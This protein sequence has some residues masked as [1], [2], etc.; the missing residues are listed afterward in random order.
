[1]LKPL[2]G[3]RGLTRILNGRAGSAAGA[4]VAYGYPD[5]KRDATAYIMRLYINVNAGKKALYIPGGNSGRRNADVRIASQFRRYYEF[6]SWQNQRY[7]RKGSASSP[8][9]AR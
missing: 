7:A 9:M 4:A 6:K 3:V 1:V 5:F 2:L 8:P